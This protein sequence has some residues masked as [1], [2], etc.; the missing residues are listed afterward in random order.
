MTTLARALGLFPLALLAGCDGPVPAAAPTGSI[1]PAIREGEADAGEGVRLYYRLYGSG[2]DT[3]VIIHGGPGFNMEYFAEDLTP[4]AARHTL[5]F[6]DQRGAGRSTLVSDSV[7]LAAERFVDD[8]EAIRSH[9]GLKRLTLLGHS[10]GA[11]VVALYAMR[12]P[13]RLERLL[14][15]DGVP[16]RRESLIAAFAALDSSRSEGERAR[17]REWMEARRANPGDPE[18]CHSYYLLWFR[19]FFADSSALSRSKGDFCAGTPESRRN[20]I[21]GVDRFTVASLGD[22]DWRPSLPAV[23]APTLLIHGSVDPL[24]L[25]GAREWAAAMPNARLLVLDGVGHFP[26]LEAPEPFFTAVTAFVQGSWPEGAAAVAAQRL[27]R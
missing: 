5:L 27:P 18:A 22:W 9:F 11:A 12:H 4:L 20:K 26:Y 21:Q 3:V 10:W 23:T 7:G 6:Y 8:L 25:A 19:P 1:A 17:M 2:P 13:E 14:I 24:P 15:V 16:P